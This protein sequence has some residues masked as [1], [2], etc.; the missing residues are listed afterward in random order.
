MRQEENY[1]NER[2]FI[3]DIIDQIP[4][5]IFWK[6][7]ESVFLGCN[8]YFAKVAAIDTPIDIIGK[9]DY[10]LP[11]GRHQG[12]LYRRDDQEVMQSKSPKLAIE[13]SQTLANGKVITLL[14]NKIPLFSRENV[15]V[16]VL[17]IFQDITVRKEMEVSLEKAKNIAE[18]ASH[19]K[20]DFIANMSHDIRTPLS[21]I[22]GMSKLLEKNLKTTEQKQQARWIHE[23]GMQLLGLLNGILDVVSADHVNEFDIKLETLDLHRC[24]DDIAKLETPTIQLKG[25]D[26]FVKIPSE[27][28]RYIVNDS[29]K[30]HRILLNLLGNAIKFTKKGHVGIELEPLAINNNAVTLRFKVVDTGIGI[31]PLIQGKI[32]ERFFK[33]SPSY[34][35]LY[36]GPG[37]GLHI[38]QSYAKL[39]GSEIKLI[40]EENRGTT[41]YFDLDCSIAMEQPVAEVPT[42]NYQLKSTEIIHEESGGIPALIDKIIRINDAPHILLVEDNHIAL[43]IVETNAVK[44][45]C[46][47]TSATNGER[48]LALAKSMEFDLIITDVGLPSLSGTEMAMQFRHW[49]SINNKKPIPIIGLTAHILQSEKDACMQSGINAVL[50]KPVDHHTIKKVVDEFVLFDPAQERSSTPVTQQALSALFNHHLSLPLLDVKK[51]IASMGSLTLLRDSLT[52]LINKE[53]PKDIAVMNQAYQEKNWSTIEKI[54]FKLKGGAIY[55]G[56]ARLLQ[57][58]HDFERFRHTNSMEQLDSLYQ[59]LLQIMV[60]TKQH[61]EQWITTHADNKMTK[62][63]ATS[64]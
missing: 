15:V 28:P 16:G 8:K 54:V 46:R 57:I 21:G 4:E 41:F 38:A 51:A 30:L 32:F 61:I 45:G 17:G 36:A 31:S 40:S 1:W 52:L 27:V 10:D 43:E 42:F 7:T 50:S 23:S 6:N 19:A 2:E 22:V 9:T 56:T 47:F 44:A 48:A 55:C 29:T 53:I 5:A 24:I 60:D 3:N 26:F 59:Q 25:L 39:L 34:K 14:T 11:W 37:V 62:E 13:E 63:Q 35:G 33:L 18:I 64:S 58:C 12:D 20:S 49:E